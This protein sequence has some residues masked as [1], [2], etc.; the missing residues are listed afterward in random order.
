MRTKNEIKRLMLITALLFLFAMVVDIFSSYYALNV[1]RI[2]REASLFGFQ[3][4]QSGIANLVV[5]IISVV[6]TIKADFQRYTGILFS[7]WRLIFAILINVIFSHY[8]DWGSVAYITSVTIWGLIIWV[9]V[10]YMNRKQKKASLS[11][12]RVV[13][14]RPSL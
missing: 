12:D 13:Y 2:C 4:I 14:S 8:P 9:F 5:F 7:I 11:N 6:I 10:P 1:C 3:T